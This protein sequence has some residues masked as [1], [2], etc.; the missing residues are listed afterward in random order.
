MYDPETIQA[1]REFKRIW[2]PDWKMNPGKVVDPYRVEENLRLGQHVQFP[3]VET[4]FEYPKDRHSFAIATE[5]CVGAGVCR[6]L[7]GG[8]MCPSYMVTL[9]EKH[10]TRGRARLLNE[11]IRQETIADGWQSEAVREALDL[12]LSCKGCKGECP[13]QVDMAVYKAEFLSHYYKKKW[14]PRTAWTMGWIHRWARLASLAPSVANFFMRESSGISRIAKFV[15]N[16]HPDRAIPAFAPLTFKSWFEKRERP[17]HRDSESVILWPDTFNNYFHPKVAKAAVEV[18]ESAG[19][20]VHVPKSNVCCGRPLYDWGLL[21]EARQ[22]IRDVLDVLKVEI[23]NGTPLVVLEPSCASVFKEE[24][25][26]FFPNDQNAKRLAAQTFLLASFLEEKAPGFEFARLE[27]KALFHGH[28][29]HKSV[30]TMDADESVLKKLELD[31]DCPDSGCCGMAGA[32]GFEKDK[33]AIA[34]KCGERLL[35]PA[36]R[37]LHENALVIADGFSCREQIAQATGRNPIHLAEA[38]RMAMNKEGK[39]KE[40]RV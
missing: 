35:L 18:L 40:A 20:R 36:V 25:H 34:M 28:C 9:E 24:L 19:F 33:Y 8:V 13:V 6:R 12:C 3:A 23:E 39:R 30:F 31:Y 32:F 5:R 21:D 16:V 38:I 14:R 10:S 4:E 15:A 37:K 22:Y 2:D 17:E 7:D 11:M 29:H 1:F 26:S 27:K